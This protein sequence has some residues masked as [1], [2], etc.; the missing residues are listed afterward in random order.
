MQKEL[1]KK[2]SQKLIK[3]RFNLYFALLLVSTQITSCSNGDDE[4]LANAKKGTEKSQA[5]SNET[6][7]LTNDL[8]ESI[9]SPVEMS[10]IIKSSG[11]KFNAQFVSKTNNLDR[12]KD[13][14]E[15]AFN[16]GVFVADMGYI[17]IY[18]QTMYTINYLNAIKRIADELKIGQFFDSETLK[19]LSSNSSN[20]DS[21]LHIST[22]NFNKMDE[23]LRQ[24]NRSELSVLLITGAWFE[25]LHLAT[26]ITKTNQS[27]ELMDRIGEQKV[28]IENIHQVLEAYKSKSYFA[29]LAEKIGKLKSVYDKVEIKY[30]HRA[31]IKKEV[32]GAL[33]LVDNS[34]TIITISKEQV[35]EITKLTEEIRKEL[36]KS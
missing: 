27:K 12:F 30:E 25:G 20:V 33:V 3:S 7:E 31:P 29:S 36:I 23:Y 13:N 2:K 8:I 32:N 18:E 24:Q 34:E 11:G 35:A 16:M 21:L 28:N 1:L 17:N 26:Q 9:P 10:E 19:R 5:M 15:R 4:L 14:N 22:T 6:T